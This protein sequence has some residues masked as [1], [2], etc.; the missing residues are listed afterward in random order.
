MA[1]YS[2]AL[3]FSGGISAFGLNDHS[4]SL[5]IEASY[6]PR[7]S[8]AQ[9]TAG[10]DKPEASNL[11]PV[12]PRPRVIVALPRGLRLEGSWIPPIRVFD[13]TAALFGFAASRAWTVGH[14]ITIAPRAS[15][16][17]GR[18]S[19]AITCSDAL[20]NGT[21]TERVYFG[22]VCHG[23]ESN[24]FFDPRQVSVEVIAARARASGGTSGRSGVFAGVRPFAGVGLRRETVRF[25]I[26]VIRSDGTRDPDHPILELRETRPYAVVGGTRT[27]SRRISG[28]T[29]VFYAPGSL[30]T[31][32]LFVSTVLR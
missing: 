21:Q 31:I 9:R 13:A 12:L 2:A 18:I 5:A 26:G 7:L 3:A 8:A 19:G 10:F 32:R 14:G 1:F 29:E 30:V 15:V 4:L 24:D 17:S 20:G 23:H 22:A 28:A 25:D 16:M 27:F 6:V 11:S